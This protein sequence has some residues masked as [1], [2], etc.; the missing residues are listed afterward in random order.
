MTGPLRDEDGR[1]GR[2]LGEPLGE[3]DGG[4]LHRQGVQVRLRQEIAVAPPTRGHAHF[5]DG[6]GITQSRL[7]KDDLAGH[8]QE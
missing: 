1:A 3:V 5:G 8:E 7:P 6:S 4:L 2:E